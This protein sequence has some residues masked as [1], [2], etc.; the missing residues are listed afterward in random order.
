MKFI[1]ISFQEKIDSKF[2]HAQYCDGFWCKFKGLMFRSSIPYNEGILFVEKN[3]S[4]LN[5]SIHMFF[6]FMDIAVAWINEKHEIVDVQ[7]AKKWHPF[8]GP[9]KPAKF[10]LEAHPDWIKHFKVGTKVFFSY[11]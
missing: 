4:V 1:R 7:L 6:M 10:V 8:Y 2:I 9:Q 5:T 11:D 3:E